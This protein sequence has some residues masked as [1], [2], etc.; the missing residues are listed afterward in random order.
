MAIR[1]A[2]DDSAWP[3]AFSARCHPSA[4]PGTS[5]APFACLTG[6][7]SWSLRQRALGIVPVDYILKVSGVANVKDVV[8]ERLPLPTTSTLTQPLVLRTLRLHCLTADYS[9]LWEELLDPAWQAD[10]GPILT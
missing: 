8:V 2:I 4:R 3:R 5:V 1:L 7:H 6:D 10:R 9:P